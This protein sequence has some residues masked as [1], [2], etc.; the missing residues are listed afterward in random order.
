M[1][2]QFKS[3]MVQDKATGAFIEPACTMIHEGHEF[4]SGGAWLAQRK[5]TGKFEGYIYANP[6]TK[7]VTSWDGKLRIPAYFSASH[8]HNFGG[9]MRH[10]WFTYQGKKFYGRYCCDY[11]ECVHVKEVAS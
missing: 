11:N 9:Q 1:T 2:V 3:E 10:M 4:T 6:E 7:E 5:D 8:R